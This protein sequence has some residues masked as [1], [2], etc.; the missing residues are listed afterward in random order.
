MIYSELSYIDFGN[1]QNKKTLLFLLLTL[2][3]FPLRQLASQCI[4]A[5]RQGDAVAPK[6]TLSLSLLDNA[7]N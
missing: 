3:R 5:A 6:Q 4:L 7:P 2:T 1:S